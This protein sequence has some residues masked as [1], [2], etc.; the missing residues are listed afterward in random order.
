MTR[1]AG[2]VPCVQLFLAGPAAAQQGSIS[3]VRHDL[4]ARTFDAVCSACHYR[5]EDKMPFGTRGPP[6]ESNPDELAQSI[7]FGKAPEAGENGMPAFG[8]VLT[9]VDVARL[10]VWLRSTSKPDATWSDV[11]ISVARMRTTGA[12]WE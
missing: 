8:T 2:L 6:A 10:M 12:R 7:L 4:G 11:G 5:G 9:D 1:R 3:P